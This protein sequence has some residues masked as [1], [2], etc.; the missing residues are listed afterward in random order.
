MSETE[1]AHKMSNDE[2]HETSKEDRKPAAKIIPTINKENRSPKK[3]KKTPKK[4]RRIPVDVEWREQETKA[5]APKSNGFA[6]KTFYRRRMRGQEEV[7]NIHKISHENVKREEIKKLLKEQEVKRSAFREVTSLRVWPIQDLAMEDYRQLLAVHLHEDGQTTTHRNNDDVQEPEYEHGGS[8]SSAQS[9]VDSKR[10]TY[11]KGLSPSKVQLKNRFREEFVLECNIPGHNTL[12]VSYDPA[13]K[14]DL[15]LWSM[16]PR[17]FSVEKANGKRKYLVGHLGRV[18]DYIWRKTDRCNRHLY[19][20]ILEKTPCRLYFDLEYSIPDNSGIPAEELLNEFY[21]ELEKELKT[22]F[23][24][25]TEGF[26]RRCIVDLDSSTSKKFSRHWIVHLPTQALFGDS[27]QVGKFVKR[28]IQRLAD[29]AGTEQLKEQRPNLQKHLF[30]NSKGTLDESSK[31]TTS[32]LQQQ[33]CFIDLGVYTRNRLFRL[34]ASTK[35]GKSPESALRIARTNQFPFPEGFGNECFYV[36]E[37]P[38]SQ[39]FLDRNGSGDDEEDVQA[40]RQKLEA[41][42]DWTMHAKALCS[43]LVVPMNATKIDYPLLPEIEDDEGRNRFRVSASKNSNAAFTHRSVGNPVVHQG[44][45]PYTYLDHFVL[46]NLANRGGVQGSIRTWTLE[47][48]P[49][50]NENRQS[51]VP[52]GLSFQMSRNRWCECV[53]RQHKSN[54]IMWNVDFRTKQCMQ[55]CYDPEC[56]AMNFRCTPVD[57]PFDIAE[58]LEDALFEEQ[59]ARMDENELLGKA[60][61]SSSKNGDVTELKN[62]ADESFERALMELKIGDDDIP[63]P[64]GIS[65][66][67]PSVPKKSEHM[68][69]KNEVCNAVTKNVLDDSLSDD[70]LINAVLTNPDLFP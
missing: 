35:F 47:Y 25:D 54:N 2:R 64:G 30:V 38:K 39:A 56:R 5:S 21:E 24:A 3:K 44:P 31:E 22:A 58:Q 32:K 49:S 66:E 65:S 1:I 70:V 51:A 11:D 43:T 33:T 41:M 26:D 61:T 27:Q 10:P 12:T 14:F 63:A 7:E 16:E 42:M 6:P 15:G 37:M 19:E 46:T 48:G 20:L 40:A 18:M 53:G 57:L 29:E 28:F 23:P 9:A 67:P 34:L 45:S 36:P 4:E 17:I 50:C 8:S 59:I 60:D 69:G 52:V 55:S 62:S 68:K 13:C